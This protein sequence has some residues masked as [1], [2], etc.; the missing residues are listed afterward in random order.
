MSEFNGGS[1]A[2]WNV[3]W[4]P[5]MFTTGELARR[6]LCRFVRPY[7][8]PGPRCSSVAAGLPAIRA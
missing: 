1:N 5:T 3:A 8:R 6:L 4:S 2:V 7:A